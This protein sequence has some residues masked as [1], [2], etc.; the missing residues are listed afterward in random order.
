MKRATFETRLEQ[1]HLYD[2]G[3]DCGVV[4]LLSTP[5]GQGNNQVISNFEGTFLKQFLISHSQDIGTN[6]N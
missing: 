1:L 3:N 6:V 2:L 4:L 5:D